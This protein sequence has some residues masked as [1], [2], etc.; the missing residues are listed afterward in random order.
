MSYTYTLKHTAEA[1]DYKLNLID[2]NKN[3][4]PYPYT[5]NFFEIAGLEDVGDGSILTTNNT[6]AATTTEVL[7][8]TCALPAGE[9]AISL[10]T[11][12]LTE[13]LVHNAS[14]SLEVKSAN[15][16]IATALPTSYSGG[17]GES[18]QFK[19]DTETVV[20]VYLNIPPSFDTNLLIKPQ[21]EEGTE[22]TTWVP[23]MDKIGN[24]V[25]GR[26]NSTNAKIKAIADSIRSNIYVDATSGD[27]TV[28]LSA[29]TSN[30]EWR[31]VY[32]SGITSITVTSDITLSNHKEAY[33]SIVF[34]SGATAT[35]VVNQ[36]GVYFTGD[37]CVTGTFIPMAVKSYDV[38]IWWNGL[39]WQGVVRGG[40]I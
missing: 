37:D 20:E 15:S 23:Y 25:D 32:P 13:N 2:K 26:F 17:M 18:P 3:L 5:T 34:I 9:Y 35:A 10:T 31:F 1:I 22:K 33:Y 27:K 7:L 38:G 30:T 40:A 24:Y 11:T 29:N 14:F 8:A 21:I 36:L 12:D 28:A 6:T 4:L 39:S 16:T 19:L